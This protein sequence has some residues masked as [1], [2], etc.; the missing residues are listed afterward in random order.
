VRTLGALYVDKSIRLTGSCAFCGHDHDFDTPVDT[1]ISKPGASSSGKSGGGGMVLCDSYHLS[2]GH[3][4]GVTTTGDEVK[5]QGSADVKGYP[6]PVDQDPGNPFY[7]LSE[8]LSMPQGELDRLLS[9]ADH[10]SIS[11]P[12]N[13]ITYIDG[14]AMINSNLV[15]E[16]LIYVTGDLQGSGNFVYKGLIYVEGD[17][18]LTGSPW[19]LGSMI[20][21]GTTDFNFSAGNAAILYSSE[22][23]S[24]ALDSVMPA[25]VLSWQDM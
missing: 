7:S 2:A 11:N 6:L 10:K 21:R 9:K 23:L 19:I 13:G 4:P 14:D 25:I 3:L 8:T 15:G 5:T 24:N 20:V 22:A 16:G 18:K 17:V 1:P 12:L